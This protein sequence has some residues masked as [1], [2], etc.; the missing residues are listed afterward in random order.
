MAAAR[1]DD[2]PGAQEQRL[3][4]D[5]GIGA[6]GPD[7]H[8][9][10]V[11]HAALLQLERH[12]R[13]D[14]VPDVFF[15]GQHLMDGC[16]RPGA[17]EI[18]AVSLG[19]QNLRGLALGANLAKKRTVTFWNRKIVLVSTP[20]NK[21]ASRIETAYEESDQRQ[22]RVPCPDCGTGQVLTWPQVKWDKTGGRH[23]PAGNGAVPLR[24]VRGRLE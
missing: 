4:D 13:E 1:I 23:A 19:V 17:V 16:A 10:R 8:L 3:I 12:L 20:T 15:V 2:L 21:G 7:P 5:G 14:I 22:Y 24:P 11:H 6:L 9:A 18:G